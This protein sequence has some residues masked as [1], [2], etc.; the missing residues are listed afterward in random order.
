MESNG[1]MEVELYGN[2]ETK[3]YRKLRIGYALEAYI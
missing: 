1:Y 2:M 3:F